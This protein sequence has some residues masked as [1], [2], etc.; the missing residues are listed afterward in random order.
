MQLVR[1]GNYY[2]R[3]WRGREENTVQ[4]IG[5]IDWW[6]HSPMQMLLEVEF[7]FHNKK[8]QIPYA[9][10]VQSLDDLYG[11]HIHPEL[12]KC[13]LFPSFV[14][15]F[16]YVR[17]NC[18]FSV[19]SFWRYCHICAQLAV[20]LDGKKVPFQIIASPGSPQNSVLNRAHLNLPSAFVWD[21]RT[22]FVLYFSPTGPGWCSTI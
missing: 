20:S 10:S 7:F 15:K 4:G 8:V 22:L 16:L 6:W 14:Q 12:T 11:G 21:V 9:L 17:H 5:R 1:N 18:H 3:A 19:F 13:K 2:L